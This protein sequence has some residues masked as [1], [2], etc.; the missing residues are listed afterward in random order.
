MKNFDDEFLN[1]LDEMEID[2]PKLSE[3]KLKRIHK[4]EMEIAGLQKP[5]KIRFNWKVRSGLV[6][7]CLVVVFGITIPNILNNNWEN[8]SIGL[9]ED[10][11]KGE[12]KIITSL[13]QGEHYPVVELSNGILYFGESTPPMDSILY[14]DPETTTEHFL[15][16]EEYIEYLGVDPRPSYVLTGLIEQPISSL[17]IIENKDGTIA[18]DNGY[19][20]YSSQDNKKS[21]KISTSKGGYPMDC[22]RIINASTS[23]SNI[24]GIEINVGYNHDMYVATFMLNGIGYEIQS[25]N[26]PQKEFINTLVSILQ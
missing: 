17:K 12:F 24:N 10:I 19:F 23:K 14:F 20:N 6:V 2:M 13:K 18:Y 21:L 8:L 16:Q 3:E 7:A 26:I 1:E 9:Q 4:I 5:Q 22:A 15:T 11:A 25:Y